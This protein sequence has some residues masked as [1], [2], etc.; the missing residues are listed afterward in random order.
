MKNTKKKYRKI[1]TIDKNGFWQIFNKIFEF[2]E[3]L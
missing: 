2:V 3:D 1:P